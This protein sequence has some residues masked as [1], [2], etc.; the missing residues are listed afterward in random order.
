M[1]LQAG[2]ATQRNVLD[3]EDALLRTR[4]ALTGALVTHTIAGLEFERDVGTLVVDEE[5]QIHGWILTN[6][7][8]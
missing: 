8:R 4:N 2:R 5:G 6:D 3:A 1:L 7:G